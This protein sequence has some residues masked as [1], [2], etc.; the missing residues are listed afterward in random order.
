MNK[1]ESIGLL[2]YWWK[3]CSHIILRKKAFDLLITITC[4]W[5]M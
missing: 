5:K 3:F 1:E 2:E 4:I